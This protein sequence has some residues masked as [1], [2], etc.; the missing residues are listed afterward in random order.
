MTG[1]RRNEMASLVPASFNIPAR[2]VV[3]AAENTKAKKTAVLPLTRKMLPDLEKW[4]HG[5]ES[6]Q[7]NLI[8]IL[9]SGTRWP[10]RM[11]PP[12]KGLSLGI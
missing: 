8:T 6:R 11:Q 7:N 1:L 10:C 3:V 9:I 4:L 12:F 5:K 2:S